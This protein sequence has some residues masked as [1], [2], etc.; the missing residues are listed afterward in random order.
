MGIN[1]AF[2]KSLLKKRPTI[3]RRF[4]L[5]APVALLSLL[6]P[7]HAA[8]YNGT[9]GFET[10]I[11]EPDFKGGEKTYYGLWIDG[12]SSAYTKTSEK[13]AGSSSFTLVPLD[14]ASTN[15]DGNYVDSTGEVKQYYGSFYSK[16]LD[17]SNSSSAK[18]RFR[19]LLVNSSVSGIV[20]PDGDFNV[21]ASNDGGETFE[22]LETYRS[23]V[24]HSTKNQ[25]LADEQELCPLTTVIF[26]RECIAS[27]STQSQSLSVTDTRKYW[28]GLTQVTI[29]EE[30]LTAHTVLRFK[31]YYD[32]TIDPNIRAHFD[33]VSLQYSGEEPQL[34]D[35]AFVLTND[36]LPSGAELYNEATFDGELTAGAVT[37]SSTHDWG[38]W[39]DG[40]RNAY[41][42]G[43]LSEGND[44]GLTSNTNAGVALK[45]QYVEGQANEGEGTGEHKPTYSSIITANTDFSGAQDLA[46]EFS[47]VGYGL[48]IAQQEYFQLSIS[49]NSG[50]DFYPVQRWTVGED[51]M[52]LN[53]YNATVVI[54][55]DIT[56]SGRL[57]Q[58][59]QLKIQSHGD[60]LEDHTYIDSIK[61]YTIGTGS[62]LT[63]ANQ[64]IDWEGDSSGL[65]VLK[66]NT[67][68]TPADSSIVPAYDL[69]NSAF[70]KSSIYLD[71]AG[72]FEGKFGEVTDGTLPCIYGA[73][74]HT[75]DSYP[76]FG[77]HIKME[78]DSDLGSDVF[79]FYLNQDDHTPL[80]S[81]GRAYP[82]P[83]TDRC[84][85]DAEPGEDSYR[86]D[87]QRMEI[88]AFS[89]SYDH[90]LGVEGET[91]YMAWRMKLPT[92]FGASDK[93][94]HLHQLKPVGGDNASMP[95]ITLTPVAGK[96]GEDA[97]EVSTPAKLNLRYSPSAASQVTLA[98]IDLADIEG[99][100]VHILEKVTYGVTNEGRYELLIMDNSNLEGEPIMSFA[101]DSLPTWKG[102][103]YVRPKWGMYRSIAQGDKVKDEKVGFAD[104]VMLELTSGDAEFGSLID[105][106]YYANS[107]SDG[108]SVSATPAGATSFFNGTT[109]A[110]TI[111]VQQSPTGVVSITVNGET[112]ELTGTQ[113]RRL[114]IDAG[115]GDDSI[116]IDPDVEYGTLYLKGGAGSDIIVGGQYD[117]NIEGGSGKDFII[118]S[119]GDDTIYAGGGNDRIAPGYGYDVVH[120]QGGVN[121]Q[122]L[123]DVHDA[124]ATN[125]EK[126]LDNH[127]SLD[128]TAETLYLKSVLDH[129]SKFKA[130]EETIE[131]DPVGTSPHVTRFH[132][133][134]DAFGLATDP[135]V[136]SSFLIPTQNKILAETHILEYER[137]TDDASKQ[138]A[139]DEI[140]SLL[141]NDPDTYGKY[142][143][144]RLRADN[145]ST[146]IATINY[147]YDTFI[148]DYLSGNTDATSFE[149]Q[150]EHTF[151][152]NNG[153]TFEPTMDEIEYTSAE[154]IDWGEPLGTGEG[155]Y[156]DLVRNWEKAEG[157]VGFFMVVEYD[158]KGA[159]QA[160]HN[161][162]VFSKKLLAN[163]NQESAK[164]TYLRKTSSISDKSDLL[165]IR[166]ERADAPYC[167]YTDP[168]T[169]ECF[170]YINKTW[171]LSEAE[172]IAETTGLLKYQL[173]MSIT[174]IDGE[175][176]TTT[177]TIT[178]VKTGY[179]PDFSLWQDADSSGDIKAFNYEYAFEQIHGSNGFT[180]SPA[181][182]LEYAATANQSFYSR[183]KDV[184]DNP[185]SSSNASFTAYEKELWSNLS[186][187][188]QT[189]SVDENYLDNYTYTDS[190]TGEVYVGFQ[191][192]YEYLISTDFIQ[193]RL[194][195]HQFH[196]R[197][198]VFNEYVPTSIADNIDSFLTEDRSLEFLDIATPSMR[199]A[200]FD[201]LQAIQL[202]FDETIAEST[203]DILVRRQL[204]L[205]DDDKVTERRGN[206]LD[207]GDGF[208]EGVD[209]TVALF[210]LGG[211]ILSTSQKIS[212]YRYDTLNYA[213]WKE[214][215]DIM[216][217]VSTKDNNASAITLLE[218]LTE[219][220]GATKRSTF[221]EVGHLIIN[222]GFLDVAD[223]F[224]TIVSLMHRI[225]AIQDG[226]GSEFDL[227][228]RWAMAADILHIIKGPVQLVNLASSLTAKRRATLGN[229]IES[230]NAENTSYVRIASQLQG[231]AGA[232]TSRQDLIDA[233]RLQ[234]EDSDAELTKLKDRVVLNAQNLDE[235]K[236]LLATEEEAI[237]VEFLENLVPYELAGPYVD[238]VIIDWDDALIERLRNIRAM[239][240]GDI[241][242]LGAEGEA[243]QKSYATMLESVEGSR[244][245]L[246]ANV[247]VS[248]IE[249][250]T[251]A[252]LEAALEA[253]TI[254][255]LIGTRDA[256][257]AARITKLWKD[258]MVANSEGNLVSYSTLKSGGVLMKTLG[259]L[260]AVGDGIYSVS[261]ALA[262]QEACNQGQD[263]IC[264]ALAVKSAGLGTASA[265]GL[266]DFSAFVFGWSSIPASLSG[267]LSFT[268]VAVVMGVQIYEIVEESDPDNVTCPAEG[269]TNDSGTCNGETRN[270]SSSDTNLALT[271]TADQSTTASGGE[272]ERAIDGNTSGVYSKRSVT[273]TS[274]SSNSWWEVTLEGTSQINQIVIFNRTNCCP[275]RL[276]NFTVSVLDEG[277][278]EI[279]SNTYADYPDPSLTI[280]LSAVGR[281]V[282]VSL[283]GTLS[284]AEVQVFGEAAEES[285][286]ALS[287][288]ADQ[289]TTASGGEPERA[290]DGNT[291]GVYSRRSVTHTSN[292]SNSWWEV[293]LEGTSQINQIVIFNRTN[294]C[295]SRLSNFTVSV[296]DE[297]DNEVW[298]N[299]YADYPDPSLTIDL[300][301]V[302]RK[303]RIS[304]SGTLS[305]AE[306]QVFGY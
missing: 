146:T 270:L 79:Y 42:T 242:H 217:E 190:S 7:L 54:P 219:N 167:Y 168:V 51:F 305:L 143:L 293:T 203:S 284:L 129:V 67:S 69:V 299:T 278:N 185:D 218:T 3:L 96:E 140:N 266:Y 251:I 27:L 71:G 32:D 249:M 87:R 225:D 114:E 128:D 46:V 23:D 300:L 192:T 121:D 191:D 85:T 145:D 212:L 229:I 298:S 232:Y 95:T 5:G 238:S 131:I 99:K 26:Y 35:D 285:N 230:M 53:R 154:V 205:D 56:E 159:F 291:S 24:I 15:A 184:L 268:L 213:E 84:R 200:Y 125:V 227:G 137:S 234:L 160:S 66:A 161:T 176:T 216:K 295:P 136:E 31:G 155:R 188:V 231:Y 59:T 241:T 30:Y 178:L 39:T 148:T 189:Y 286:L 63:A 292:S 245:N 97:G 91:H 236:G 90:Q 258:D 141:A 49:T 276:S 77:P 130:S 58:T 172:Q 265:L 102:G 75:D 263:N 6:N 18:L 289:S 195:S 29:P 261:T 287:G 181:K 186:Y 119:T 92:G 204:N 179:E 215:A 197:G 4:L 25:W 52:N 157:E 111:T 104:I 113:T 2:S 8:T 103:D 211:G 302:G 120:G 294:C 45:S 40:G 182:Y 93:F 193:G 272:P 101:S 122:L 1:T 267:P 100:W 280:D 94:T 248:R 252:E 82:S 243:L 257:L 237:V 149:Y 246:Q 196:A 170:K 239:S 247:S 153:T 37:D 108:N 283:S 156:A 147:V 22:I 274:N 36:T 224:A 262:A 169:G 64:S 221:Y 194:D 116:I 303:V 166:F 21:E 127:V 152:F 142:I 110:D 158:G 83:D 296:L 275:S 220:M 89:E 260:G 12:G 290:I 80:T 57:T 70:I 235:A 279:W 228:T 226:D 174:D 288:T 13:Y 60:E 171:Y 33:S 20:L 76:E 112:T 250:E 281:K 165:D 28:S 134:R 297:D 132:D 48:D 198:E 50:V 269:A 301:E 109:G 277:D 162:G 118:G 98:S 256:K 10:A 175:D 163:G 16:T 164:I 68:H 124:T 65:T 223:A 177:A 106:A 208:G 73:V 139:L 133:T 273:H 107:L 61:V 151:V 38:I 17:L 233:L 150:G 11:T 123:S 9:E 214:F 187:I 81:S 255:N 43:F 254:T 259:L 47:F 271:G 88:K 173:D 253:E 14:S 222:E 183:A 62:G 72:D 206:A 240:E 117:D 86:T 34:S 55:G 207:L 74:E 209:V 126:L 202:T 144:W 78:S 44:Y 180:V 138:D 105:F 115:S 304:L 199:Q 282:R 41:L 210:R 306:V 135:E 244:S 264:I 201:P 19:Y